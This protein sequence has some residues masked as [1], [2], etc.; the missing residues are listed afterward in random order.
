MR[1]LCRSGFSC[2][3]NAGNLRAVPR[4][5][6]DHLPPIPFPAGVVKNFFADRNVS[7]TV[8]SIISLACPIVANVTDDVRLKIFTI[9]CKRHCVCCQLKRRNAHFTLADR[10]TYQDNRSSICSCQISD[11]SNSLDGIMP[12]FSSRKSMPVLLPNPN[13]SP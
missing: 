11:R 12:A 6:R 2:N 4:S 7:F 10:E 3:D 8:L 13:I 5:R 9:V 1:V